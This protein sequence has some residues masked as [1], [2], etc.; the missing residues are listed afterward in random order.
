MTSRISVN[1]LEED[2]QLRYQIEGKRLVCEVPFDRELIE[3]LRAALFED[4]DRAW[5]Y[6]SLAAVVTVGI[7]VYW[8][9]S[10]TP[11]ACIALP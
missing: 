6:P 7:G 2:T 1:L 8:Y 3:K 10:V 9:Q 5:Q 11:Q 4:A